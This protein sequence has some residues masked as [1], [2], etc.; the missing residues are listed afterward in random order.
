MSNA[1][2]HNQ[3]YIKGY[4]R[5][6]KG[7]EKVTDD[8]RIGDSV[9]IQR[10]GDVIPQV[11]EVTD[12]CRPD[13]GPEYDF[14]D[15]CP[16]CGSLAVREVDAKTGEADARMRC[17]GGLIDQGW[18]DLRKDAETEDMQRTGAKRTQ[19]FLRLGVA[20]LNLFSEELA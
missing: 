4:R 18:K 13:R 6:D 1:T 19:R 20:A 16:E 17:T 5:T 15:H 11:L 2:L 14:P 9:K 12:A 10:A 7:T 8:I 3:D